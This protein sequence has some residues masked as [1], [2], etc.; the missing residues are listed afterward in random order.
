MNEMIEEIRKLKQKGKIESPP[1]VKEKEP[2]FYHG[3]EIWNFNPIWREEDFWRWYEII[4]E[5]DSVEFASG[6]AWI[7]FKTRNSAEI[8]AQSNKNIDGRILKI[9][10]LVN[11]D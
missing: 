4:G 10:L 8:A 7:Y 2:D 5:I 9:Q 3:V 1:P 6:I 11:D